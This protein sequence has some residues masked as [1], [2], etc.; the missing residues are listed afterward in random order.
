MKF[1]VSIKLDVT[2]IDKSRLFTGE[3]GTYLD[4]TTFIEVDEKDQYGNSGFVTQEQTK[5]E[6]DAG[7]K[8]PILG[9]SKV[10]WKGESNQQRKQGYDDGIVGANRALAP[11]P[12]AAEPAGGDPFAD[13]IPFAQFD[14]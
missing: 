1:G 9:N 7:V 4:L 3:K 5:E 13:D 8:L 2:K 14:Y 10:F 11:A 6:K 12:Q